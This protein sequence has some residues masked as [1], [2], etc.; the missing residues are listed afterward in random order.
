M[1]FWKNSENDSVKVLLF[2]ILVA[3]LAF[4]A[5][6]HVHQSSL[7][8]TGQIIE[9]QFGDTTGKVS[10]PSVPASAT[11]APSGVTATT[12]TFTGTVSATDRQNTAAPSFVYGT[13]LK[14]GQSVSAIIKPDGTLM[15]TVSG[16]SCGTLYY[17]RTSAANANG[18]TYGAAQKFTTLACPPGTKKIATK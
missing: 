12:A 16:L 18:H 4:F 8:N 13:N 3:F 14:Y 2:V 17:Y 9:S 6:E 5:Y 7:S 1:N 15:A 10:V 11:L